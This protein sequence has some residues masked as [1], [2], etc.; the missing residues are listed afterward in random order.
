LG[1][2][3]FRTGR[4]H[5]AAELRRSECTGRPLGVRVLL[6]IWKRGLVGY[7]GSARPEGKSVGNEYGVPGI[8]KI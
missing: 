4:E 5:E 6:I 7:F 2:I 8:H 1:V 3:S